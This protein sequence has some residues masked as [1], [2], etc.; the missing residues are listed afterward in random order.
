VP[1]V[2]LASESAD[3]REF[4]QTEAAVHEVH[5]QTAAVEAP[6]EMPIA[7]AER[8]VADVVGEATTIPVAEPPAAPEPP[9][10]IAAAYRA[11]ASSP[12][13]TVPVASATVAVDAKAYL[14]EA[15]LQLVETDPAKAASTQPD[16]E[17][18]KLG[19]ARPER[20]RAVEEELVQVETRK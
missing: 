3:A 17:P 7:A 15:G 12:P 20:S 2:D 16:A 18:E 8:P 6:L 14:G 9:V 1:P 11:E 13:A 4:V 5:T 19:R 10:R